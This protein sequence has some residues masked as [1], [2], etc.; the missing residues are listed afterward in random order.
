MIR[1]NQVN[2]KLERGSNGWVVLRGG[3]LS[4]SRELEEAAF[5]AVLLA[6]LHATS[7]ELGNGV[8]EEALERARQRHAE[9]KAA[10]CSAA[11]RQP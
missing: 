10:R 8:P 5:G 11:L 1:E 3:V 7:V 4:V 6:D 2:I 9:L